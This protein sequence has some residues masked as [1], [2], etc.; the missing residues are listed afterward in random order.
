MDLK[1]AM[2]TQNKTYDTEMRYMRAELKG[3]ADRNGAL[4]TETSYEG[5]NKK[6]E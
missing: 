4:E 1:K 5:G 2:E 3:L 6:I